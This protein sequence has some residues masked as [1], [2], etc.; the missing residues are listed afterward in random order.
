[1]GCIKSNGTIKINKVE[2]VKKNNLDQ[3]KLISTYISSSQCGESEISSNN[4]SKQNV[5]ISKNN[6]DIE[7]ESKNDKSKN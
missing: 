4:S 5:H 1:M 2:S 7:R 6:N 3:N